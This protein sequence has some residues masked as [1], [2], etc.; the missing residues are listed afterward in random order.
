MP[1]GEDAHPEISPTWEVYD[2]AGLEIQHKENG[3]A[4]GNFVA[5][6]EG[7]HSGARRAGKQR[8]P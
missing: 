4:G 3:H 8:R 2:Q 1:L 6:L 7:P 5:R